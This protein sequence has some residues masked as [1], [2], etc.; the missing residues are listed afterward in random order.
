M[1]ARRIAVRFALDEALPPVLGDPVQLEQVVLNIVVNACDAID[2]AE[3]GPRAFT[4]RTGQR[5][6]GRLAIAVSD[7]GVGVKDPEL[8]RRRWR[9]DALPIAPA[10]DSRRARDGQRRREARWQATVGGRSSWRWTVRRKRPA[11]ATLM[12]RVPRSSGST[13]GRA[14]CATNLPCRTS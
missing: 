5:Q 14:R 1:V 10:P 8:E 6:P 7:T 4:I 13:W 11:P 2:A 9:A 3:D 12:A